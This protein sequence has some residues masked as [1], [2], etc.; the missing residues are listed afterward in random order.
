MLVDRLAGDLG[1]LD[2]RVGRDLAGDDAEARG[3][4]GLARHSGVGVFGQDRVEHR[5]GDLVGHLVGVALGDAL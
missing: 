1:D 4:H 2:V 3:E 5:I